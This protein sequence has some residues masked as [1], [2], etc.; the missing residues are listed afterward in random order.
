MRRIIYTDGS[1]IGQ[2]DRRFAGYGLCWLAAD[3]KTWVERSAPLPGSTQ[4]N[5]RSEL[6][7]IHAALEVLS[8]NPCVATI[9]TDSQYSINCIT[10]WIHNWRR[11]NWQT[12]KREP[13][14]NRD[15]IEPAAMLYEALQ[16]SGLFRP[17]RGNTLTLKVQPHVSLEWV[18]AHNGNIGNETADRLATQAAAAAATSFSR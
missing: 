11:N 8:L 12:S 14:L 7:A 6:M 2:A 1:C 5:Q 9:V 15:L 4:T 17:A 18:K 13:V 16:V 10:T 3:G